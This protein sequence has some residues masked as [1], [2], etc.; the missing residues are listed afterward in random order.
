MII[1]IMSLSSLFMTLLVV[2]RKSFDITCNWIKLNWQHQK[3]ISKRVDEHNFLLPSS[4]KSCLNQ[5]GSITP[6]ALVVVMLALVFCWIA[7]AN[8]FSLRKSILQREQ[9]VACTAWIEKNSLNYNLQ[10]DK[11]NLLIKNIR[12]AEISSTLSVA[13][14]AA[15][16]AQRILLEL[17]QQQL[18][19]FFTRRR[20]L[21]FHSCQASSFNSLILFRQINNYLIRNNAFRNVETK[22]FGNLLITLEKSSMILSA[23][24][25]KGSF[26]FKRYLKE[27]PITNQMSII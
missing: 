2:K 20:T 15:L 9:L 3:Q 6:L 22:S 21:P 8:I 5:K 11:L 7:L 25:T 10:M 26:R 13:G 17:K 27:N 18:T 19:L 14:A 12:A 16:K 24:R 1:T 4:W 23:Q